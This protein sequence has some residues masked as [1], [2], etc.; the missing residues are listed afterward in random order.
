M[1]DGF[2][3]EE[4][5]TSTLGGGPSVFFD[6]KYAEASF[7]LLF[8]NTKGNKDSGADTT[9]LLIGI[10]GKYPFR[11]K[12]ILLFPL[13]GIDYRVNIG[14]SSHGAKVYSKGASDYFNALSMLGGLGVDYGI[15]DTLYLRGELGCG[16]VFNSKSEENVLKNARSK[17][18]AA[19]SFEGK[20]FAKLAAGFRF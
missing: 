20:I 9:D 5:N 11:I 7:S 13:I 17:D 15:G 16:F 10:L 12:N 2:S 6:A 19:S 1:E 14:A 8:G 3:V 4:I 18:M